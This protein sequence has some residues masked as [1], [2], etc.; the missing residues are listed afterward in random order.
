MRHLDDIFAK[1][2]FSRTP[3]FQGAQVAQ[4]EDEGAL[5]FR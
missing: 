2:N 3:I 5:I 4:G 1:L